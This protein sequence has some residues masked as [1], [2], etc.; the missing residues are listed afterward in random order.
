MPGARSG[1][2]GH[3]HPARP[4][5]RRHDVPARGGPLQLPASGGS[6]SQHRD[7]CSAAA[8]PRKSIFGPDVGHDRRLERHRARDRDRAQHG[9]EVGPVGSARA[10]DLRGRRQARCSSA[11]RSRSTSRCRD[12]TARRD[13]RGSPP[14]DRHELRS[15]RETILERNRDKLAP[16]GR[17]AHQVRD[18]RRGADHATSWR[19]A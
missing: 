3:D 16:D 7:A 18:H 10:A 19:G 2:Q 1:L 14:R 15:A 8:S 13:R 6:K 5:A 4:G 9:H 11:V 12:V 17:G